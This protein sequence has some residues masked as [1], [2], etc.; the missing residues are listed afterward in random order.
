LLEELLDRVEDATKG[1]FETHEN[2]AKIVLR[3]ST[4]LDDCTETLATRLKDCL[5][6]LKMGSEDCFETLLKILKGFK[7]SSFE[8]DTT[9]NQDSSPT[10]RKRRL[11]KAVVDCSNSENGWDLAHL[12][13]NASQ[14]QR[15]LL[16]KQERDAVPFV[17]W[18][19]HGTANPHIQSPY[20]LAIAKLVETPRTGAGG[21][22]ERLAALPPE[23]LVSLIQQQLC[24]SRPSNKDWEIVI[25]NTCLDRVR[26]LADLLNIPFDLLEVNR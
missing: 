25:G 8:E 1:C 22:C 13:S 21:A 6:T 23:Q 3:R 10:V 7:D 20:S 16:E 5:A 15:S 4:F 17:S 18:M 9:S 11:Q 26:L 24:L 12:L 14:K 2:E 19:I